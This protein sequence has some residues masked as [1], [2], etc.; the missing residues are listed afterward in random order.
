MRYVLDIHTHTLASGHA[1]NTMNEMAMAAKEKRL[2]L[3]CITDHGPAMPGSA[4]QLYFLNLKACRRE[5]FGVALKIG[6]E[7]NII[8]YKGRLDLKDEVLEEMDF[9]IASLHLPCLK[10]GSIEQNTNAYLGAMKNRN[11]DV[12]GHPDDA[13]YP[14][15]YKLFAKGAKK[16][17]IIIEVNNSSLLPNSF[18]PGAHEN[19][20]KLLLFCMEYEI[21]IAIGS[22][23]HVEE[24]V[25]NFSQVD[26]LLTQLKFPDHL[27]AN[28][29][30]AKFEK[31]IDV[32]KKSC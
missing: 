6:A 27:I 5:K 10:P 18:R 14:I 8:D 16:E 22:D 3:L 20:Y 24:E 4:K 2:E 30:V 29:S 25:G 31:L 19:Y 32:R 26:A 9:C 7:V 28:T 1:Y 21:P 15:D 11:I 12:I 17:N 13:R 23:A